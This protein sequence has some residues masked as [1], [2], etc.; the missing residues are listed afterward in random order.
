MEATVRNEQEEPETN[1]VEV[2]LLAALD[3]GP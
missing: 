2:K 3:L 1:G